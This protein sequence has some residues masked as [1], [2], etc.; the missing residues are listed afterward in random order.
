MTARPLSLTVAAATAVV[1]GALTVA[2]GGRALFG[3]ADMGAVVPFV[4]WFHFAAGFAYVVAGLGLWRGAGWA[5]GLSLAIAVATAA[6]FAAFL[7][8]VAGGG[9]H[10]ARTTAAMTLRT[11]VWV[12]IAAVAFRAGRFR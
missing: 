3:G 5:P 8:H 6:V 7:W 10:E 9:A 12:A 2:A 1:F 11:L 4:L